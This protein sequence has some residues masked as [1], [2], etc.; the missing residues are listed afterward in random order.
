MPDSLRQPLALGLIALGIVWFL[1]SVGV[2]SSAVLAVLITYWPIL[3]IGAGLDVL[4]RQGRPIPVPFTAL[5]LIGLVLYAFIGAPGSGGRI[6]EERLREAL[7]NAERAEVDLE[8]SSATVTL[9]ATSEMD[10]LIETD[11]RDTA[12]VDLKVRGNAKKRIELE[13][14]RGRSYNSPN[15]N[16]HWTIGLNPTIP[17]DLEVEGGSGAADLDLRDLQLSK[18]EF[19]LN[20]GALTLRLP[21]APERYEVDLKG[22][23]GSVSVTAPDGADFELKAN[24]GSGASTFVLAEAE[25]GDL[26]LESGSGSV[27]IDVPDN[28]NVKLEVDDDASGAL[29]L[30]AWL[31]QLEGDKGEGVWQTEGFDPGAGQIVIRVDDRGS[32]SITVK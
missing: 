12:K 19:E 25:Y 13:R 18:A 26:E 23:S 9:G 29:T 27:T 15:F 21:N 14:Q 10:T 1:N 20:S 16:R 22:G 30:P 28:A 32:G 24:L 17:L 31:I 11:I 4:F 5:A 6:V 8:L 3:L 7:G 2:L